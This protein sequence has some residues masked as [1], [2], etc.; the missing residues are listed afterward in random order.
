MRVKMGCVGE[1]SALSN[2]EPY[3]NGQQMW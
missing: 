2:D 1:I 3:E